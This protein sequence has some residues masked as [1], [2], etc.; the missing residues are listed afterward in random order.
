[1]TE[2]DP[3][4]ENVKVWT[5]AKNNFGPISDDHFLLPIY[6]MKMLLIRK[7]SL[8]T[9]MFLLGGGILMKEFEALKLSPMATTESF[10]F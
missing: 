7:R 4:S 10:I 6:R 8:K 9:L 1:M 2:F 3:I 5:E